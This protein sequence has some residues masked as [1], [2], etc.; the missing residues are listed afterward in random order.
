M[1]QNLFSILNGMEPFSIPEVAIGEPF[2]GNSHFA[3]D[4]NFGGLISWEINPDLH[5]S[6][7]AALHHINRPN[8]SFYEAENRIIKRFNAHVLVKIE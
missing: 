6:F 1:S 7:G 3:P 8:L 5:S 4:F 2:A